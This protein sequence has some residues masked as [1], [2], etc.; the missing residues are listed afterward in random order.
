MSEANSDIQEPFECENF[1]DFYKS[2]RGLKLL[3]GPAIAIRP[4]MTKSL[5]NLKKS[6]KGNDLK[7]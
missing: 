1:N 6:G 3:V 2:H 4:K 5:K 7:K